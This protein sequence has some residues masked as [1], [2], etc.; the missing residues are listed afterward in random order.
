MEAVTHDAGSLAG[1]PSQTRR[2]GLIRLPLLWPQGSHFRP[3][4][5]WGLP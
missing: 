1:P 2:L 5:S 3:R 4:S